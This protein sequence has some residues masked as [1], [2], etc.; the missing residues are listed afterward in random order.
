MMFKHIVWEADCDV[1]PYTYNDTDAYG[2]DVEVT[3]YYFEVGVFKTHAGTHPKNM[4]LPEGWRI[5]DR[6]VGTGCTRRLVPGDYHLIDEDGWHYFMV[7]NS[8]NTTV[9]FADGNE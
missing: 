8:A 9:V 2:V 4:E 5:D 7:Y 1:E 3:R 6:P